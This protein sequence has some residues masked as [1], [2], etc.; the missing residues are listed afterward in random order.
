MCLESELQLLQYR[1]VLM[2]VCAWTQ[3]VFLSRT[4]EI[5]GRL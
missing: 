1:R 5:D 2:T 3:G 4:V